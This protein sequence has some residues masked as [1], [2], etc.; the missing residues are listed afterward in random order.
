MKEDG[1]IQKILAACIMKIQTYFFHGCDNPNDISGD[2]NWDSTVQDTEAL[3]CHLRS[4][5]DV[6]VILNCL[7]EMFYVSRA[8][9]TLVYIGWVRQAVHLIFRAEAQKTGRQF[10]IA[11]KSQNSIRSRQFHMGF[12]NMGYNVFYSLPRTVFKLDYWY[13]HFVQTHSYIYVIPSYLPVRDKLCQLFEIKNLF[14]SEKKLF[15]VW[16]LE[17]LSHMAWC[18]KNI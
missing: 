13:W 14:W 3:A 8:N 1:G 4:R 5:H 9:D 18:A 15:S 11:G 7:E 16:Q 10:F 12:Q 17:Y 2:E 6:Y